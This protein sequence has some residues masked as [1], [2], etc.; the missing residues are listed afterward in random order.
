MTFLSDTTAIFLVD[1][2]EII[3]DKDLEG[4]IFQYH[5]TTKC[6]KRVGETISRSDSA[7]KPK[8]RM[9]LGQQ[10]LGRQPP[11]FQIR[12]KIK[13]NDYRKANLEVVPW[14]TNKK[15]GVKGIT[16][17]EKGQQW[18]ISFTV[19]GKTYSTKTTHGLQVAKALLRELKAKAKK[20]AESA[21]H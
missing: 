12:Q 18:R 13:G 20:E 7:F 10:V 11:G 1:G 15:S 16:W 5:W 14:G 17:I 8:A 2:R 4:K 19:N 21:H 9:T 6:G 3:I